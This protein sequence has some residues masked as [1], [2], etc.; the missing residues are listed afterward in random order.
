MQVEKEKKQFI[1]TGW[2]MLVITV[3]FF[4]VIFGM[5]LFMAISAKKSWTGLVVKNTYVASQEYNTKL[6]ISRAQHELGWSSD[7]KFENG[8]LVF[9]LRDKDGAPIDA[10]LVKL[11]VN[12]VVGV[13]GELHLILEKNTQGDYISPATLADGVWNVFIIADVENG[14]VFEHHYQIK[15]EK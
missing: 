2:H 8:N 11:Q 5:N 10:S 9:S 1:F 14:D 15:I 12:R 6:A 13:E 4:V 7:V 3:S